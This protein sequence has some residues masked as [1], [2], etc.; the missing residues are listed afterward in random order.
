M[1]FEQE[2]LAFKILDVF[3]L[4]L[5]NSKMVV[6][7]RN[8][9]A[10]SLRLDSD[11]II[12][13]KSDVLEIS[14]G[15]I[16][17]FPADV[18][19]NR[20]SHRDRLIVVHFKAL[21]YHS[22]K[23]ELFIP[24]DISKYE[25][26][27]REV[28]KL[29]SQKKYAYKHECSAVLNRIFAEL[30]KDNYPSQNQ[31]SKILPSVQYI[32]AEYLKK[33]FSLSVAAQKS[34]MSETY[35]RRLFKKEFGVSPKKYVISR[36]IKHAASLIIMGYFSL[37]EISD[38]CGYEDYKHFSAEFKKNTGVSPSKYFYNYKDS[39]NNQITFSVDR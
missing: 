7:N 17:F 32:D 21:N 36:R 33:D 12:E 1:I 8:F 15:S 34:L 6:A 23:I 27:F 5:D 16:C 37:Q 28:L 39:L 35:F 11:T 4:N 25:A 29:W 24:D 20:I 31:S 10:L 19:Y 26:L 9:D 22:N 14:G 30:Y 3:Y 2:T 18:D 13:S 38:M